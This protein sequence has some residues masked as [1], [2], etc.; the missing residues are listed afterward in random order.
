MISLFLIPRPEPPTVVT[1]VSSLVMIS[2]TILPSISTF[3]SNNVFK[4]LSFSSTT[5]KDEELVLLLIDL[6]LGSPNFLLFWID[7]LEILIF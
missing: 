4:T 6:M 1:M 2:V 7:I 5:R 3:G